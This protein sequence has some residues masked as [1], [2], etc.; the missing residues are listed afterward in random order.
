[1]RIF[2]EVK[3]AF[4]DFRALATTVRQHGESKSRLGLV[5]FYSQGDPQGSLPE[6]RLTSL[7]L[8][9]MKKCLGKPQILVSKSL[10]T[11]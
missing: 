2:L 11:V 3:L 8:F 10:T 4:F 6:A 5:E 9:P 1:M 7:L